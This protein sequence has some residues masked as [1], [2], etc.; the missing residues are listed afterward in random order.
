MSHAA[1]FR[2]DWRARL[3]RIAR[4]RWWRLRNIPECLKEESKN[5]VAEGSGTHWSILNKWRR[6]KHHTE[7]SGTRWRIRHKWM[8]YY[9]WKPL[10]YLNLEELFRIVNIIV[11]KYSRII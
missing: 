2:T 5:H 11:M 9:N 7:G 1:K 3:A 6:W 4:C 8:R 10:E